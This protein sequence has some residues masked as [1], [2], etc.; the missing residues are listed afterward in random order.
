[1][2]SA[3]LG[4]DSDTETEQMLVLLVELLHRKIE[5]TNGG[6]MLMN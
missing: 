4:F 2:A 3:F 6:K 1:M 5:K